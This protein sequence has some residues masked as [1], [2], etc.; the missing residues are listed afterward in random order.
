MQFSQECDPSETDGNEMRAVD[1]ACEGDVLTALNVFCSM[2]QG[3][4]H[5]CTFFLRKG[6][7]LCTKDN[8]P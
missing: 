7:D 8:R 5:V 2:D 6:M 1:R 4:H 3:I